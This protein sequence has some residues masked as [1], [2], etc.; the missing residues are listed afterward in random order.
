MA[1]KRKSI[2]E[3][4]LSKGELR[5]LN[6]LRKSLGDNIAERAFAQ[7]IEN[8]DTADLGPD[9][10]A[11]HILDALLPLIQKNKLRIPRGGF[12]VRR[13]RGRVIVERPEAD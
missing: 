11:G 13:G 6:A 9:K 10:N 2:D 12:I 8:Q 4:N 3:R 5:K 7:W 1:R